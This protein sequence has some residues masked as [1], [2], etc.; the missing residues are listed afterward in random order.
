MPSK[1]CSIERLATP[2]RWSR[3]RPSE[4]TSRARR[5]ARGSGAAA[6]SS[7]SARL[8]AR[9]RAG[10]RAPAASRS[11]GAALVL[12][13]QLPQR[14]V[15]VAPDAARDLA[16]DSGPWKPWRA[17]TSSTVSS[18]REARQMSATTS[19]SAPPDRSR[20][21]RLVADA[22]LVDQLLDR[23]VDGLDGVEDGDALDDRR[24]LVALEGLV[25][26]AVALPARRAAASADHAAP[27]PLVLPA[28]EVAQA[29]GH[30]SGRCAGSGA[31]RSGRSAA[32]ARSVMPSGTWPSRPLTTCSPV[33]PGARSPSTPRKV[34]DIAPRP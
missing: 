1:P 6:S 20:Q 23:V 13:D 8:R 14:A 11:S 12:V 30:A 29:P 5:A 22:E 32:S 26:Q 33:V 2:R 31:A 24:L 4:S 19:I 16:L 21:L 10:R 25:E 18:P 27:P 15:V 17:T 3:W 34:T 7:R 9:G 28:R